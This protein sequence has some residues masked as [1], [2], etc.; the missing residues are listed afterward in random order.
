MFS[1][2]D[3]SFCVHLGTSCYDVHNWNL[4]C[5]HFNS[6][7]EVTSEIGGYLEKQTNM[8]GRSNLCSTGNFQKFWKPFDTSV[9]DLFW[10]STYPTSGKLVSLWTKIQSGEIQVTNA[11]SWRRWR[12]I[13]FHIFNGVDFNLSIF[14]VY[15]FHFCFS[16]FVPICHHPNR[17]LS[18]VRNQLQP[19][20]LRAHNCFHLFLPSLSIQSNHFPFIIRDD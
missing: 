1:Q 16:C 9:A 13:L 17:F 4:I 6:Q 3:S 18:P 20:S 19:I 12:I 5:I 11:E 10:Y 8:Y 2:L 14:L 7:K 15:R